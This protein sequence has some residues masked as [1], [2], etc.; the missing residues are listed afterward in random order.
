MLA[1]S[2]APIRPL[3]WEPPHAASAALKKKKK[4][5]KRKKATRNKDFTGKEVEV[6]KHT[7]SHPHDVHPSLSW[8]GRP[9]SGDTWLSWYLCYSLGSLEHW[10]T[11]PWILATEL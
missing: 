10:E 11:G 3:A 4:E 7:F 9:F 8:L 5:K 1:G 2:T 6:G